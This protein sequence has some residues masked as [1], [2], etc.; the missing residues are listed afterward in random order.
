MFTQSQEQVGGPSAN[1][2]QL[3]LPAGTL[4]ERREGPRRGWE[5]PRRATPHPPPPRTPALICWAFLPVV[6]KEALLQVEWAE[7]SLPIP[8]PGAERALPV[9]AAATMK[10]LGRFWVPEPV[11]APGQGVKWKGSRTQGLVSPQ[12]RTSSL[13]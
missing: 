10:T 13:L 1:L 2:S 12:G 9:S 5:G 7:S 3:P 4:A 6:E 8:P 11:L